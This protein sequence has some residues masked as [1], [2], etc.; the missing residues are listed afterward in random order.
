METLPAYN[1]V[2]V[3]N[4]FL[5]KRSMTPVRNVIENCDENFIKFATNNEKCISLNNID[6]FVIYFQT[7]LRK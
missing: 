3:E 4:P 2:N 6:D 5:N 1:Y 7:T